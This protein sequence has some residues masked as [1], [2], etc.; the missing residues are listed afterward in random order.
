MVP[1]YSQAKRDFESYQNDVMHSLQNS[2]SNS[3]KRKLELRTRIRN[4]SNLRDEKKVPE[5]SDTKQRGHANYITPSMSNSVLPS[6]RATRNGASS[7][8]MSEKHFEKRSSSV[9]GDK[10]SLSQPPEKAI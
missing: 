3:I 7:V 10:G 6:I 9:I 1:N 8:L 4:L 5:Y 2:H